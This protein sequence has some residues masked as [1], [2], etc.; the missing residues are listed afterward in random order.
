MLCRRKIIKDSEAENYFKMTLNP[1]F[2]GAVTSSLDE[3][4]Y[5]NKINHKSFIYRVL[6]EYLYSFNYVIYFQK[7]SPYLYAFNSK[8]SLYKSG[9]LIDYWISKYLSKMYLNIQATNVGPKKLN[10]V[11]LQGGFQVWLIGCGI[12]SFMF[13]LEFIHNKSM[14]HKK[15][16]RPTF[17][18]S[19]LI[20]IQ[21]SFQ[22]I[23][24]QRRT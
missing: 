14:H 24:H 5:L 1:N 6:P 3:V 10:L 13:L 8:M 18:T 2:K 23:N 16:Q 21:Q 11:Q 4:L 12:S 9:G 7:N 20:K 19:Q 17:K 15:V 22:Q